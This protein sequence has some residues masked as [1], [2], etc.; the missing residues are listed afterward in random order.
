[1][2]LALDQ[3]RPDLFDGL[4]SIDYG[5]VVLYF[6][7]ML[8]AGYYFSKRQK[9][10]EEYF[11]AGRSMPWFVV[12]VSMFATLLST[13]SY[14]S[15]PGEIIK[16]G[17]GIWGGQMHIPF[18]LALVTLV[19]IPFFM[20]KR[21][22]SA[23]EYLETQYGLGARLFAS[24][25]FMLNRLFWMGMIVYT[26]SFAMVR[27]TGLPFIWV[28]V[29][30]GSIAIVYTTMGG[31]RA[32]IWTDVAQFAI[33]FAGLAFTVG[34]VFF[35]TGTGPATWFNDVMQAERE[36]QPFFAF[37]PYVRVS[38]L[39]MAIYAMFWWTC[40][41]GS[42][43]VAIQRYLTTGSVGGA[44]RSFASN[45]GADMTIALSLGLT[46]MA[47]YS[48]YL[49]QLPGT[50]D[51]AFPHFIAHGM[52]RGLAGLVVAALFSAAMSS[53]D[54]GMHG[55]ATVL[56]VDFFRRLRKKA[57]DAAAE[58]KLARTITI[59][60]GLFAVGFCLYLNTIPEETR[61]NL[62][63]LTV[64]ISSYITGALGG[65]FFAAFLRFRCTGPMMIASG[66]LGM[67]V[68]FYLSLATWLQTHPDIFIYVDA[69]GQTE[70]VRWQPSSDRDNAIGSD[71][72]ANEFVLTGDGVAERHA[73]VRR[74]ED[75]WQLESLAETRM[76]DAPVTQSQI[77]PDDSI[78]IAGNRLL[79]K[80]KAV[81][82]MWV[83]PSSCLVTLFSA[84]LLGLFT[85]R[86]TTGA[87]A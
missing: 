46:G 29:G 7:V 36:P 25:L 63:D 2:L 11:M 64:R 79:V 65:M 54:S 9:S 84:G 15:S 71:S 13:V 16:N 10:T 75:G 14:L 43:Q 72:N 55:V 45:L 24:I 57:L 23:Y 34:F 31:M 59:L 81:S 3:G 40:T 50:P 42:D 37:D 5:A 19:L 35:E 21:F 27:M 51:Q 60:A 69:P 62:F 67:A 17:L 18:T 39:G 48:F 76:N 26:A 44:Q 61:G 20:R 49:G 56:T 77:R 47:L 30:I 53:L 68:G 73:V 66:F 74:T 70:T 83:L 22:T 1:M 8:I 6:I 87:A 32:V 12:G 52:P 82:W 28:V 33:L 41:A 38:L 58:L 80:V 4:Q 86:R 78:E 85:R